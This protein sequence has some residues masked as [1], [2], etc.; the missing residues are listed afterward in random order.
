[1]SL[2][3]DSVDSRWI[4]GFSALFS[5]TARFEISTTTS[6]KRVWD[7]GNDDEGKR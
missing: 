2:L 5:N 3:N 1:M 6:K 7:E 4:D